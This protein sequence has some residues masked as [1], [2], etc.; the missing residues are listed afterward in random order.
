MKK[1]T[2]SIIILF[3]LS[4]CN[5]IAMN[6]ASSKYLDGKI[7]VDNEEYNLI[8]GYY[9]YK[10]KEV[11]INKLD[12]FSP[13]DVSDQF[14]TLS[15]AKNSEIKIVLE[16]KSTF[17]MVNQWS[18]NSEV[19]E[20]SLNENVLTVPTEEGYYVYEVIGKWKNGETTLVFDIDVN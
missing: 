19:K 8:L 1:I 15:V 10:D 3:I 2:L 9:T 18:E 16:D 12:S 17:M 7:L 5:Q 11:E 13:I 14:E 6:E 4:G 20:V